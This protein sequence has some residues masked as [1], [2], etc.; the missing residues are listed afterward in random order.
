[1]H[2]GWFAKQHRHGQIHRLIVEL[3]VR[4]REMV[5]FCG[6]TDDRVGT[7]LTR[8]DRFKSRQMIGFHRQHIALLGF[9]APDLERRHARFIVRHI[10]ELEAPSAATVLDQ[11]GQRVAQPPRTH[12][13]DK[14]NGIISTQAPTAINHLLTAPLYFR[15]L[16]LHRGKVEVLGAVAARHGG[17]RAAAQTNQHRGTTQYH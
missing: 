14:G 7:A 5:G 10:A 3:A 2:L 6:L 11:F 9:V 4:H 13:V 1:M 15:V 12:I 16:S 8:T 17:R